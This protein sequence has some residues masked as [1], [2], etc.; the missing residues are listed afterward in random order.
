V[1]VR[2]GS[3]RRGYAPVGLHVLRSSALADEFVRRA[4]IAPGTLAVDL[5][6]GPGALTRALLD[7]GARVVAVE[8]DPELAAGL[9][10]RFAARRAAI[11]ECDAAG[12]AW[13]PR[14]PFA[15][16][17][18][19]PFVRSGEILR[20]LLADP[21]AQLHRADLIVQWELAV[22]R[23]ATWPSTA[24]S[25][26]FGAW[27]E[28]A[29]AGRLDRSAFAP[30]PSVDA[31]V[32]RAV[33]R[34]VPLVRPE[35]HAAYGALVRGAFASRRPLRV[36]LGGRLSPRQL[37]RLAAA[38]GFAASALARDLDAEQWAAV[39]RFVRAAG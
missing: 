37:K 39:Y 15:V 26:T 38:H 30:A 5:G 34:A 8:R 28:L 4:G 12:A 33:R 7:A 9:R 17:A 6:A 36:A 1:S 18:N 3:P 13:H 24:Q 29:I 32:L 35:D 23:A 31:G 21:A 20:A 22:K 2:A 25:V 27:Y 16:V 10:R 14:E 19:L 11:V